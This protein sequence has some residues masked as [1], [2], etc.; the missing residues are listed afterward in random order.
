[1]KSHVKIWSIHDS[2]YQKAQQKYSKYRHHYHDR[3]Y[4]KNLRANSLSMQWIHPALS[5]RF[6]PIQLRHLASSVPLVVSVAFEMRASH[7]FLVLLKSPDTVEELT[8][9]CN[10]DVSQTSPSFSTT[11]RIPRVTEDIA[12]NH[13]LW[14]SPTEWTIKWDDP[15]S[16]FLCKRNKNNDH[17]GTRF[18][19]IKIRDRF[20]VENH[21]KTKVAGDILA[22]LDRFLRWSSLVLLQVPEG[23]GVTPTDEVERHPWMMMLLLLLLWWWLKLWK[24]LIQF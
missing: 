1:M 12:L 3:L 22:P 7:P 9:D 14:A 21:L 5:P 11:N 6:S 18:R 16:T 19:R 24:T 2:H 13:L 15:S 8:T 10:P 4:W 17:N 23:T 20:F